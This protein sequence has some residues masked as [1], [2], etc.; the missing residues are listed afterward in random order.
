MEQT[1]TEEQAR[2]QSELKTIS[3][4]VNW[5]QDLYDRI[6]NDGVSRYDI[7]ALMSIR[8]TINDAEDVQL[9]AVPALE[10]YGSGSFTDERSSVN[11]DAGLEGI[12]GTIVQT[13]KR[14]I[15]KLIDY[16]RSIVRW[17]R[18]NMRDEEYLQ[19]RLT[20]HKKAI[21]RMATGSSEMA[22]R[23]VKI[24]EREFKVQLMERWKKLLADSGMEYTHENLA[25]LGHPDMVKEFNELVQHTSGLTTVFLNM[26]QGL[27]QFLV[28]TE[29]SPDSFTADFNV[30]DGI[31]QQKLAVEQLKQ[32]RPGK[33]IV[34]HHNAKRSYFNNVTPSG[35]FRLPTALVEITKYAYVYEAME[36]ASD[37]LREI[38]RKVDVVDETGDV[39]RILNNASQSVDELNHVAEFLYQHNKVKMKM[40]KMIADYENYRFSVIFKRAKDNAVNDYQERSLGK[41]RKEVE[42][43]L[44]EIMQ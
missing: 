9:D 20:L 8:N 29:T 22:T 35:G 10:S 17:F 26:T 44:R 1:F 4:A 11:L 3:T 13:I 23:Y 37:T 16:I 43:F 2:Y 19:S 32:V 31:H 30:F 27:Y 36:K 38:E 34:R 41:I 12:G 42:K 15:K 25:V 39:V 6:I 40:L 18:K 21:D 33:T 7:E 28:E 24:D 14:W 5:L